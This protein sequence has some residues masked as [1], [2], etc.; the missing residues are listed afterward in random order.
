MKMGVEVVV[1]VDPL[2][3]LKAS[4][5]PQRAQQRSAPKCLQYKNNLNSYDKLRLCD[6]STHE[7]AIQRLVRGCDVI[8]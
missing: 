7:T 6:H 8:T 3:I 2:P 5:F 4:R 1:N